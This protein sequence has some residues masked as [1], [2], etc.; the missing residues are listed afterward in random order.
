MAKKD[1]EIPPI[2]RAVVLLAGC[3]L[4]ALIIVWAGQ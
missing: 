1:E 2:V 3:A 4:V